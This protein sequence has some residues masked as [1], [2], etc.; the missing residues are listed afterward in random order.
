MIT[1]IDE[2]IGRLM[3]S[4]DGWKLDHQ[5]LLIFMTDNG[6]PMRN[7]YNA[8]MHGNKG[9]AYEGGTH[10]PA[11]WRWTGVLPAGVDCKALTAH[12]DLFPTFAALA[13]AEIPSGIKLDGRSLLPLLQ[14]P[15]ANWP[16]RMLF[17]HKGR[18]P[19]GQAAAA[20]YD[21]CA[22]RSNRFR[23][24]NNK[25]LYDIQQ[26][27]GETR[28]VI[29]KYPEEVARMRA[30]YDQWWSEVLPAMENEDAIGPKV[31][32]FKARYWKQFG[33]GPEDGSAKKI[34]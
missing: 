31:N 25:E 12:I 3:A 9:T 23:L 16:D 18:W 10:V 13:G 6:H 2:N 17:V 1:N 22:V 20:K 27:P 26:D 7:L 19:K 30:A 14:N 21:D 15:Q 8:G 11:F 5:T 29:D 34:D 24:V 4:L 32:P 33:G 28:N